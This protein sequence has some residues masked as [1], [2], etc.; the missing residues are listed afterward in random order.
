MI[1]QCKPNPVTPVKKSEFVQQHPLPSKAQPTLKSQL[2]RSSPRQ[3][4][5]S[6]QQ[7]LSTDR[8]VKGSST[9]AGTTWFTPTGQRLPVLPLATHRRLLRY[10]AT[11]HEEG[12]ENKQGLPFGLAWQRIVEV[13]GRTISD[14]ALAY[15]RQNGRSS[16]RYIIETVN[17]KQLKRITANCEG[18]Y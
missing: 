2:S 14:F 4:K 8:D 7:Q 18:V 9:L 6:N 5:R 15:L 11:G 17:C 12:E 10:L 13:V 3:P 1:E 16:L